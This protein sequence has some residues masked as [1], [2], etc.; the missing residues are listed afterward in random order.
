[1]TEQKVTA[2]DFERM[3]H[4]EEGTLPE[5]IRRELDNVASE[6]H[7]ADAQEQAEYVLDFLKRIDQKTITRTKAENLAAFEAGW[8]EN[9]NK[10]LRDGASLSSLKP[11]YFRGNKFLRYNNQLIVSDNL[12]LEFDLFRIARHCIFYK[13]LNS[14]DTICELGCGS[15]QNILMLAELF[16][17]ANLIAADWTCASKKIADQLGIC[18]KR[19]ISGHVLDMMDIKDAGFIPPGSSIVT[20]HAFEQLGTNFAGILDFM[21]KSRPKIVVQY[22]PVLEYYS[23]SNLYDFLAL[24][25]C[26][27]RNYLENYLAALKQ[28]EQEKKIEIISTYRPFLGGV[29]HESSLI[30]WRPLY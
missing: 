2:K 22:E 29:L 23:E 16:K 9:Y 17:D 21:I 3:F 28:L 8:T 14:S 25:Y 6:H 19:N 20:I 30:V 11:G 4:F 18:L 1:M 24:K 13:Y 12:Q 26:R 15:C 10:L 7:P 5:F 27:K